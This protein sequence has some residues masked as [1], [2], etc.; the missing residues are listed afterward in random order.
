M[1]IWSGERACSSM[2]CQTHSVCPSC[3]LYYTN[4]IIT[5]C[6]DVSIP[7]D[8]L[9]ARVQQCKY[10]HTHKNGYSNTKLA[11]QPV[12]SLARPVTCTGQ[13]V[14]QVTGQA[15]TVASL[16]EVLEDIESVFTFKTTF[17][18]VSWCPPHVQIDH[19]MPNL[20]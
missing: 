11:D 18:N 1:T 20:Q 10:M 6:S 17:Y 4:F 14:V 12:L 15:Y 16:Q 3:H 8:L 2:S 13:C 7:K 5:Q 9:Q 19:S